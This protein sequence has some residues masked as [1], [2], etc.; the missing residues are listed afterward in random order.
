[1]PI[2][3]D[4]VDNNSSVRVKPQSSDQVNVRSNCGIDMHRLEVLIKQ[5]QETKQNLGFVYIDEFVGREF[6]G[7][8]PLNLLNL[9]KS[10][11]IN[12]IAYQGNVYSLSK[13]FGEKLFYWAS[14]QRIKPN[15]IEVDINNGFFRITNVLIDHSQLDNLDYLT[16]GHNGFAGIE[17]G[18][19][20]HWNSMPD[21]VPVSG[22][23]V[24]YTDYNSY[25]DPETGQTMYIPAIKIGD[26]NA[27]L[28]N[29]PF[30]GGDA[31]GMLMDHIENTEV[32]V[33][34]EEKIFWSQKLNFEDPSLNP[35]TKDGVDV[36]NTYYLVFTR[37]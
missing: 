9:L 30:V 14:D 37:D 18:T 27:Y 3:L 6:T 8:I 7:T 17:F 23:I 2:K 31:W 21:Y 32:H 19:T 34:K 1:M 26:G 20:E 22:M 11:L 29:K 15:Q 12:K 16:S 28:S 13:V 33:T 5:L 25:V 10:Y 35:V 36:D 24:V 4:I